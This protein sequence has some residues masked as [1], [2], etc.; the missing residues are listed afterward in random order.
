MGP[1]QC[2]LHKTQSAV[3]FNIKLTNRG[4]KNKKEKPDEDNVHDSSYY[5]NIKWP[6]NN[7]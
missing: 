2:T 3:K 6:V 5:V 4:T 1:V 7:I